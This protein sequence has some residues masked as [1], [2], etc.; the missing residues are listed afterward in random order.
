MRTIKAGVKAG[1]LANGMERGKGRV[2]HAV[3][4]QYSLCG[5]LPANQWS[6]RELSEIT[7]PRCIRLMRKEISMS[8][9]L[10]D[11]RKMLK[12]ES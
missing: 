1:R 6:E 12:E 3:D 5:Q 11:V 2:V 7:C 9:M 8:N 10:S 4:G